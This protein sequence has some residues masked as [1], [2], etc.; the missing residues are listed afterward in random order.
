MRTES[1][2]KNYRKRV[3]QYIREHKDH[4]TIQKIRTNQPIT[5]KELKELERM[6][7]DGE[8]RG[9]KEDLQKEMG[10]EQP[11]GQFIRSIVGLDAKAAKAAFSEFLNKANP[12]PTWWRSPARR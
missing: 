8:E 5:H 4:L 12:G 11:L 1:Q 10:T 6:L 2:L 7:F 3:E 9:T